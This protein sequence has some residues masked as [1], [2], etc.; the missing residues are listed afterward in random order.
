MGIICFT[1]VVIDYFNIP[2]IAVLEP[3]TDPPGA[4][5][6]HRPQSFSIT[7]E[8][9]QSN[10][11]QRA[12]VVQRSSCVEDSQQ[13]QGFFLVDAREFRLAVQ[14]SVLCQAISRHGLCREEDSQLLEPIARSY[15]MAV[16]NAP[17]GA[18]WAAQAELGMQR[19]T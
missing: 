1:L 14:E 10:G 19:W 16:Y 4:V 15:H 9:V 7:G 3:E 13:F 11:P 18:S 2:S 6:R 17:P 12:E 5:Y 8:L